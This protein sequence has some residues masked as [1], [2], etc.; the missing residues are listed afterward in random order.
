MEIKKVLAFNLVTQYH[1]E[2]AAREG[3]ERFRMV[4]QRREVPEDIPEVQVPAELSQATWVDLC[5][6]LGLSA[7]KGEVRRLMKQGGFYV[8]QEP[9]KDM[10]AT[11][12][13]P[14][15]GVVIRLGKRRYYRLMPS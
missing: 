8:E 6:G 1:D 4:V 2:A 3:E 5:A 14:A 11:S 13:V 12:E 15:E 7:S 10:E 9:M